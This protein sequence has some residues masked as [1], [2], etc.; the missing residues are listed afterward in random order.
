MSQQVKHKCC[1]LQKQKVKHLAKHQLH[2]CRSTARFL[3]LSITFETRLL[4][5]E[6]E[7]E[8][9]IRFQV[10]AGVIQL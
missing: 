6:N 3:F 1:D 4:V 5:W 7:K 9:S 10:R 2:A 8:K